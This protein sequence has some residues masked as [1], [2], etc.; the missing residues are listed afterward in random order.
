[1]GDYSPSEECQSSSSSGD[2]WFGD[3]QTTL[4]GPGGP[5]HFSS[6]KRLSLSI[7]V[8]FVLLGGWEC[9]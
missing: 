8:F 6:K 2:I 9:T 7:N 3:V 5:Y 4:T 1:M